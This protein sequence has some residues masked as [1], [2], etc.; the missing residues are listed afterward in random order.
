MAIYAYSARDKTGKLIKGTVE[1]NNEREA[2]QLV[3]ERSLVVTS[4]S[5]QHRTL[6]SI[7]LN[8]FRR[9]SSGD[10]ANFTRQ[11]STMVTAGLQIQEAL[12]LLR[13][14][15][16]NPAFTN[17]LT[18]ISREIQGGGNLAGSLEKYPKYFSN[19]YIA[20]IKAGESSGTL[21][22]VLERLADN[23]EKDMEFKNKVKGAMVYPTIIMIAMGIVF[24]LLMTLVVP[25]LTQLYVDFGA[26]LPLPTRILQATSD[27]MVRFW[28]LLGIVCVGGFRL[29]QMWKATTPGKKIWDSFILRLP[30]IGPL[31]E[32]I[33]LVEFTRTLGM[34]V[35]AGVHILDSLNILVTSLGNI[36]YQDAL[37][38]ITKKVEKGFP[39]GAL[40]AQYSIFPPILAQ[41]IKVGEETGKLDDSLIKL[42]TYFERESDHTV[43]GLTTAIEPI[44]MVILGVGVGFIVFSIITPIYQLTSQF[45]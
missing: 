35:G 23:L 11:L 31:T 41:M 2:A 26:D 33:I 14:Q 20:L 28:W 1:A 29:F 9:V 39:M 19:T 40:F 34:L 15:S 21:D 4:L 24:V 7:S 42:S 36:H 17:M 18:K 8:R 16:S 43:K 12:S 10:I 27:F 32:Q 25:K 38:D 3:R 13:V 45:K 6:S 44:I 30:L 22:R 37:K 5:P